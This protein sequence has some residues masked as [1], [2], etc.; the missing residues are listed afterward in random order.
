MKGRMFEDLVVSAPAAGRFGRRATVLPL[1]IAAHAVALTAALLFPFL[2]PAELP[3]PARGGVIWEAPVARTPPRPIP[4]S[5]P[6]PPRVRSESAPAGRSPAI[7][8]E[9]VAPPPAPGPTVSVVEPEG[10]PE[11]E[12]HLPCLFNCAGSTPDGGGDGPR[13]GTPGPGTGEGTGTGPIIP[14]GDIKPPVRTVYVAPPY[15]D[16]ARKARIQGLVVVECTID[17]SGRV[18]DARVITGPPL[19]QSAA[20]DAVRQWRYTPTRLNGVPVAVLMTV[21]VNF[22]LGR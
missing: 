11:D 6:P 14:G 16:L 18:V 1:S 7:A 20:L 10:I 13:G 22:T 3:E 8:A 4:A 5:T 21:T 12:S 2:R 17:P 15:P 9:P 19:L